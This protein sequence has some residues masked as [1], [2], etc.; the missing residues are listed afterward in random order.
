MTTT[1]NCNTHSATSRTHM[2]A[3]MYAHTESTHFGI[4]IPSLNSYTII[5]TSEAE[6]NEASSELS[7]TALQA[8]LSEG[9][10]DTHSMTL[11]LCPNALQ[12]L[13]VRWQTV[14]LSHMYV[15]TQLQC[16]NLSLCSKY[17]KHVTQCDNVTESQDWSVTHTRTVRTLPNA[18]I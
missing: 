4:P 6:D 3:R 10:Q 15:C 9:W 16:D 13:T 14:T 2:H 12:K 8:S 7:L 1:S 17:Y 5:E 18:F 11:S